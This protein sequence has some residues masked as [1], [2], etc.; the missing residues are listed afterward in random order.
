MTIMAVVMNTV[1]VIATINVMAII[2][3]ITELDVM[4][5]T[6]WMIFIA[7]LTYI[8]TYIPLLAVEVVLPT[9]GSNA[10]TT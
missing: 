7:V 3:L 10:S 5:I 6:V 2:A 1:A 4:V 8:L 9:I